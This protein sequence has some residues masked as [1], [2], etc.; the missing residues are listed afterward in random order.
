MCVLCCAVVCCAYSVRVCALCCAV[1]VCVFLQL[2]YGAVL[3][4][5]ICMSSREGGDDVWDVVC[6]VVLYDVIR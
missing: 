5:R 1:C 6:G 3:C 2:P 4:C